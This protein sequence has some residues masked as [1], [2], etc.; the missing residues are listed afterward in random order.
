M[1][2]TL[3][4][5]FHSS[6]NNGSFLQAYAL[7][8]VLQKEFNVQN[9]IINLQTKEQRRLYSILRPW[10]SMSNIIKNIISLTH[11]RKLKRRKKRFINTRNNFLR[12]TKI[13]TEVEEVVRLANSANI[14]IVGSDQ[15]WNTQAHDFSPAYFLPNI[16]TKKISYA[17][18]CGSHACR[19]LIKEYQKEIEQFS[20]IGVRETSMIEVLRAFGQE[21]QVTV[22][23]TCL[24]DAEDYSNLYQ[25]K[26]LMQDEYIFLYSINFN[27]TILK[28][29]RQVSRALGVPVITAFTSY[30]VIRCKKYGIKVIWDASPS[31]FLNFMVNAKLVLTNSF[32]GTVFSTIFRKNFFHVCEESNGQFI[33]DDRIDDFLDAVNL[34]RNISL[35]T[36][37]DFLLNNMQVN[38]NGFEKKL[39]DLRAESLKFL[40]DAL[41]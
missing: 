14:N 7:Q 41:N 25:N 20:L 34:S 19:D 17:V 22:D 29:A 27:E 11:Y 1:K 23:P 13:C 2:K 39:K 36:A 9:Q 24:L 15:I 4:I 6:D 37:P 33:R 28:T 38:Y 40:R 5:T 30:S 35:S 10:N 26:P 8:T 21:A 3:T 31:E 32:H 16:K 18:S 12:Q